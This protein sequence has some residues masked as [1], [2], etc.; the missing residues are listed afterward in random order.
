MALVRLG[1]IGTTQVDIDFKSLDAL[2]PH[3]A[4]KSQ[5]VA[6]TLKVVRGESMTEGMG[7]QSNPGDSGCLPEAAY[8]D[9]QSVL[10]ERLAL[11]GQEDVLD[12]IVCWLVPM[13]PSANAK[14][15]WSPGLR[16]ADPSKFPLYTIPE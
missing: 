8:D 2:V 6:A 11:T 13:D 16:A 9:L 4:L 7:A 3:D 1:Q 10:V 15:P 14:A 5:Q 12:L